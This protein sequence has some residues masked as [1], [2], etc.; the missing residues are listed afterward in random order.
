[1]QAYRAYY[2]GGQVI[3]LGNPVIPEGSELIITILEPP[4]DEVGRRQM[5]AMR[6]FCEENSD[7]DEPL[8]EFERIRFREVEV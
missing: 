8:P 4:A 7:C 6:R 1:M 2:K 5:E 3:P